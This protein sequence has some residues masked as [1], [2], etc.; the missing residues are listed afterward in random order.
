[1]KKFYFYGAVTY[2][3]KDFNE[4]PRG[5]LGLHC[6]EGENEEEMRDSVE[7]AHN[8]MNLHLVDLFGKMTKSKFK[9]YGELKII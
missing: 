6:I 4:I 1:M 9:W 3:S 7:S 2:P 5:S 8:K